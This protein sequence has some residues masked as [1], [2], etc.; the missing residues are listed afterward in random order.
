MASYVRVYQGNKTI[1]CERTDWFPPTVKPAHKGDYVLGSDLFHFM[2]HWD[3]DMWRRYDGSP[4]LDQNLC[5]A[6]WTGRYL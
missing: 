3:G 6:G 1:K 4:A 2:N 5:W